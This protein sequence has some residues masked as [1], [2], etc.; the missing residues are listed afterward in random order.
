M[1]KRKASKV[2]RKIQTIRA[3]GKRRKLKRRRLEQRLDRE[4]PAPEKL[5]FKTLLRRFLWKNLNKLGSL[6]RKPPTRTSDYK[7]FYQWV[8]LK[9]AKKLLETGG[10]RPVVIMIGGI[11]GA[12]KTTLSDRLAYTFTEI[13]RPLGVRVATISLDGYFKPREK[14]PVVDKRTGE[15]V[16]VISKIGGKVIPGEYDNPAA[17][18]LRRAKRD[19][20]KIRSGQEVVLN[21]RD[22][23]TGKFRKVRIPAGVDIVIIE[24]L[25][26]LH[27][28]LAELGD[29]KIGLMASLGDQFKVRAT[30]DIIERAREPTDVARKF[31]S[32]EILQ[33]DF[34]LPTLKNADIIL[35]RAAKPLGGIDLETW[36]L[37][38]PGNPNF[39]KFLRELGIEKMETVRQLKEKEKAS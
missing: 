17:S 32:R 13:F 9:T 4:Y 33:R 14:I 24:G 8:I 31:V 19:I 6:R 15:V 12:G 18:D 36:L 34:V 26:T 10:K 25:Y 38:V 2:G 37:A 30:R 3:V 29:I 11:A 7:R 22:V 39:L 27:K 16:K 5:G 21:L 23:K 1:P 35:D 20:E 28:P